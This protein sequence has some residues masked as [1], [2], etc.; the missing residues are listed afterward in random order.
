LIG[1]YRNEKNSDRGDDV[2]DLR[3]MVRRAEFPVAQYSRQ[4]QQP[5]CNAIY[6]QQQY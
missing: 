4:H 1:G 2:A 6:E 3:S 5:E